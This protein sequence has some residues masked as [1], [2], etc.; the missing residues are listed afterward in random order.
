MCKMKEPEGRKNKR[1]NERTNEERASARMCEREA[2]APW[3]EQARERE[4][5]KDANEP[6]KEENAAWPLARVIA[7][8]LPVFNTFTFM[9]E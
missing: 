5:I 3:C 8:A 2:C 6:R 7:Q 9:A 4:G 1:T